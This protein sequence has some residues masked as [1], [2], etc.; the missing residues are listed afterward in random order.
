MQHADRFAMRREHLV[1]TLVAVRRLVHSAA[2]QHDVRTRQP[3]LHHLRLDEAFT[4]DHAGLAI[5]DTSRPAYVPSHAPRHA[6]C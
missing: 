5:G 6:P 2:T 1:E 4:L 3:L